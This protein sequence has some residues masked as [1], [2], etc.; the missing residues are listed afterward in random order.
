M[1][2]SLCDIFWTAGFL[3]GEGSFTLCGINPRVSAT[4]VE[5]DP[6]EKLIGLYGGKVYPKK[7]SGFGKKPVSSWVLQ[8]QDAVGLMMTIYP[9]MCTRRQEQISYV[10]KSWKSRGALRGYKHYSVTVDN[11]TA[12]LALKRILNGE[13]MASVAKDLGVSHSTISFW[14]KGGNRPELRALLGDLAQKIKE[15]SCG[16]NHYRVTVSDKEALDAMRRVRLGESMYR[17]AKE[18][19]LSWN[20]INFWMRG[21]KRPYLLAQLQQEDHSVKEVSDG[22]SY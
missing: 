3:E 22:R 8:G 4:Q 13:S 7:I 1:D 6:L 18:L 21:L 9:L 17:I 2:T 16:Q 12:V 15:T 20:T 10:L 11:A 14:M 19:N 5:L